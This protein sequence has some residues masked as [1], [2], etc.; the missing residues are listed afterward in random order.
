M[1]N[2]HCYFSEFS[3]NLRK[4]ETR[5][6]ISYRQVSL[7]RRRC[8]HR[9]N[10]APAHGRILWGQTGSEIRQILVPVWKKKK[11]KDDNTR[12]KHSPTLLLLLLF[13]Y[14]TGDFP[15]EDDWHVWTSENTANRHESSLFCYIENVTRCSRYYTHTHTHL[16]QSRSLAAPVWLW[17]G[18][19]RFGAASELERAAVLAL[20]TVDPPVPVSDREGPPGPEARRGGAGR[21][22][23]CR[24]STEAGRAPSAFSPAGERTG[25]AP[26]AVAETLRGGR[27]R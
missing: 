27:R 2:L 23:A 24:G 12:V 10:E 1:T 26:R 4:M 14:K 25:R 6:L 13:W 22:A 5:L 17:R 18:W 3:Q 8:R 7:A 21:A 20:G 11:R 16:S 15:N 19:R 9:T